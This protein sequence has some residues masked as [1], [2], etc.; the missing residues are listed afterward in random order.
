[1][2]EY[3]R[4]IIEGARMILGSLS[5]LSL[6]LVRVRKVGITSIAS[7]MRTIHDHPKYPFDRDRRR[8]ACGGSMV[9]Q[10]VRVRS[11]GGKGRRHACRTGNSRA[12][13]GGSGS[14]ARSAFGPT[15]ANGNSRPGALPGCGF[16][17]GS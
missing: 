4:K 2:Y 11:P 3:T 6:H 15:E 14:P 17:H 7:F 8:V 16:K 1:M 13:S 5:E 12:Q 9:V 10:P